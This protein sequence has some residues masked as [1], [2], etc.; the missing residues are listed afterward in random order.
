MNPKNSAVFARVPFAV[1]LAAS[2]AT[3]CGGSSA[4]TRGAAAFQGPE[5]VPWRKKTHEEREAFMGSHVEPTM[6]RVFQAYDAKG[7][8]DFGCATC[9]GSDMDLVDFRM[10]NSLYAL[11]EKDTI[12]SAMEYDEKIA[13]FMVNK[14]VPTFANLL[15]E[16]AAHPSGVTCFTC[17][18]KE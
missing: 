16:R 1:V 18:P 5:D 17:H 9:H 8:A 14:V 15:S 3:A 7:F 2:L 13:T 12:A 6:R 4:E 11:P 10:P